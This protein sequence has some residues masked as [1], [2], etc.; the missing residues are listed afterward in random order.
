MKIQVNSDNT[1]AVDASLTRFVRSEVL[2]VLGRFVPKLTRIE[3]HLSDI[4]KQKTG[5]E[6]KRCMIEARPAGA[7]PR[8][9][10]AVAIQMATAIDQAL[11]KMQ[12]SL[13]TFFGKQGWTPAEMSAP[14]RP[15]RK[16]VRKKVAAPAKKKAAARK[17]TSPRGPK[18][19]QVFRARREP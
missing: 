13:T 15:M 8:S 5:P 3:V 19:K 9:T 4:N 2:R 10:T 1:V 7:D 12:R 6:D 18:M 16:L 17:K 14:V 11:K